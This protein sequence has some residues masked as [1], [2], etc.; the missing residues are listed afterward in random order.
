MRSRDRAIVVSWV[1]GRPGLNSHTF[2]LPRPRPASR[3]VGARGAAGPRCPRERQPD[4]AE[5]PTAGQPKGDGLG[6]GVLAAWLACAGGADP[7]RRSDCS[8]NPHAATTWAATAST[9]AANGH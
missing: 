5:P 4:T 8:P 6:G 9:Q 1:M 2:R 7:A 3:L